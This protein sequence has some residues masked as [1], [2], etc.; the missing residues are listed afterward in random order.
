LHLCS[1]A[2]F[3]T[4]IPPTVVDE[5]QPPSHFRT[6]LRAALPM[7]YAAYLLAAIAAF[8]VALQVQ[9]TMQSA[10]FIFTFLI[11][12]QL[13]LLLLR[14]KAQRIFPIALDA[15]LG[16]QLVAG[17]LLWGIPMGI[18]FGAAMALNS[19]GHPPEIA[20]KSAVAL[21]LGAVGGA[22]VGLLMY[23]SRRLSDAS[24]ASSASDA[25]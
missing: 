15:Q 5:P 6:Q 19:L 2:Y 17:I 14:P 4:P 12:S 8:A 24:K 9:P 25:G 18:M 13:P 22:A 1:E 20:I 10:A 16:R 11:V 7:T 21:P 23:V 3:R